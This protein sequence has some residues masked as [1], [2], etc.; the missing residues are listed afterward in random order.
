MR[1]EPRAVDPHMVAIE[2]H[3]MSAPEA[4]A[5]PMSHWLCWLKVTPGGTSPT[6]FDT[7]SSSTLV[8]GQLH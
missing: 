7:I 3:V 1:Q 5:R 8:H 2:G 6:I 4:V